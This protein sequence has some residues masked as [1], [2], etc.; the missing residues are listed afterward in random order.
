VAEGFDAGIGTPDV[1]ASDMVILRVTGPL[2]LAV[3]GAPTYFALR[4]APR[5]PEDLARHNCIEFRLTAKGGL[6]AWPF[7]FNGKTRRIR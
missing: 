3:V 5:T 4:G 6:F 1:A 2:R 7:D